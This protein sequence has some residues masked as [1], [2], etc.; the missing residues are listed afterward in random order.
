MHLSKGFIYAHYLHKV[1]AVVGQRVTVLVLRCQAAP[2]GGAGKSLFNLRAWGANLV[3]NLL[4]GQE[5]K[6]QSEQQ[7]SS[8]EAQQLEARPSDISAASKPVELRILPANAEEKAW[9]LWKEVRRCSTHCTIFVNLQ[10]RFAHSIIALQA[11]SVLCTQR[12]I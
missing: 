5:Q 2:E 1:V 3:N 4:L 11:K 8:D 10:H 6:Q 7:P 12:L 9:E